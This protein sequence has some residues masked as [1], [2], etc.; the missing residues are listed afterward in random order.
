MKMTYVIKRL[1]GI[2]PLF[3]GITLL[4]FAVLHLSPGSPVETQSAFNTKM[5]EQA[6]QKL[7][8]LYG[9]DKPVLQRYMDWLGRLTRLDFGNS[10]VDGE[11]VAQKIAQAMPVTIFIGLFSM[12][13]MFFLGVPLGVAGALKEGTRFDRLVT[14]L[15][16]AVFSVPTFWLALVLISLFGVE[17][18]WLP[19]TGLHSLFYEDASF[20][21]RALDTARHLVL[22]LICASLARTAYISRFA[23][24]GMF[25][26]LRQPFIRVLRAKGLP[27]REVVYRHALKNALLPLITLLGL[28]IPGILGGSVVLES[29]FS[30]PGMGRLFFQSVFARDYPVIMGILVLGAVLTLIGNL[31]ADLAYRVADPRTRAGLE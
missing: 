13:F 24:S 18:R 31:L 7:T 19:V 30:I 14:V 25:D 12:L 2:I 29:V 27:E 11:P 3:F 26:T 21:E 5:T 22:P 6:K 15:S 10:F 9:L 20:L 8:E 28:S 4:S 17:L 16:L 23:R 1:L